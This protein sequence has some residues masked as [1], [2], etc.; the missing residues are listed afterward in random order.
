MDPKVFA[1]ITAISF[2]LNPVTLKLGFGKGGRPDTAMILGLFIAV[3]LYL[4]ILPFGGGLHWDQ[5]TL[6]A[7]VGFVLGGLFGTGIGRRWLYIAIDRIGASPATAI[8]NSA[9]VVTT[10]L[11]A[12]V[13]Q[14]PVTPIRW[15]AVI[16]IV[17]GVVLVTWKPGS[18]RRQWLDIGVAAAFGAMLSYGVRPLFLKF[19]L[20]AAD[21]PLT[22]AFVGAIAALIYALTFGDRSGLLKARTEPAFGLFVLSG[23]L[24][25]IGFLALTLGLSGGEVSVVYPV[26]ASA[27]I[28]TLIFTWL[29]LRGKERLTWRIVL[30]AV[31][32][33]LGVIV[34]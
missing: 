23:I 5:V 10:F 25:A 34:L 33:T 3:P 2:G 28:F 9:P 6:A 4:L 18:G 31:L 19:G 14:E 32:V 20:E 27:P 21:L 22:A 30:G 11:A 16:G 13:Y 26:T 8:K 15:L 29:L 12:L 1:L 7:F 17:T 24:Q